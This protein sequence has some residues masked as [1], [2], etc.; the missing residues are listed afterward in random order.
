MRQ[1]GGVIATNMGPL[2][3]EDLEVVVGVLNAFPD[4]FKLCLDAHGEGDDD[5]AALQIDWLGARVADIAQDQHLNGVV[6]Q[7]CIQALT[8]FWVLRNSRMHADATLVKPCGSSKA[9][10]AL[11]MAGKEETSWAQSLGCLACGISGCISG[12]ATLA[13]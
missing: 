5:P 9:L 11:K 10:V 3:A 6:W 13:H 7:P 12:N 8:C 4:A 2:P 1:S